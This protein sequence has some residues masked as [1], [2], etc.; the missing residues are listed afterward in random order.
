MT[1][2]VIRVVALAVIRRPETGEL[3]VFEGR[4]PGRNL[5]YHR[6]LGGEVHFGEPAKAA[7]VREVFEEIG[8]E[9]VVRHFITALESRFIAS[10]QPKHEIALLFDCVFGDAARYRV[11]LFPDREGQGEPG[12]WRGRSSETVLFP[13]RL[14][15][16]LDATASQTPIPST[17]RIE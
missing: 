1:D 4:D 9:I 8:E 13:D 12:I 3:L 14:L 10:G 7:V 6:P 17:S 11:D 2:G 5:T 15:E 16:T